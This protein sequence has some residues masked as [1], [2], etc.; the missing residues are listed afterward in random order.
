MF[1]PQ[2]RKG[3]QVRRNQGWGREEKIVEWRGL[4]E[5]SVLAGEKIRRLDSREDAKFA[6]F[7]A[8]DAGA[9]KKKWLGGERAF[10]SLASWREK[11]GTI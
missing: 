4:C 6:K 8:I 1:L 9:T 3:R 10:A 2:R 11:I 7:G 5:L